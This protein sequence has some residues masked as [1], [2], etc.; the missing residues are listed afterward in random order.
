MR[1]PLQDWVF[2]DD[3]ISI[4]QSV[5]PVPIHLEPVVEDLLEELESRDIIQ[6]VEGPARWQSP[7]H[8]V[9]KKDGSARLI[10]Q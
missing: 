6:R 4:A 3:L 7:I 9:K 5:R 8:L 10:E 1:S 2:P